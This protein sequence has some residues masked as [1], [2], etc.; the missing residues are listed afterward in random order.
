MSE[1][2]NQDSKE[3]PTANTKPTSKAR[4]NTLI[5]AVKFVA[6]IALIVLIVVLLR[7][8]IANPFV[9]PSG[10]MENTILEQDYILSEKVSY[11]IMN[12]KPQY[13]DI[14]TFD[15]PVERREAEKSGNS[16]AKVRTLIKRVIATEGQTVDLRDGC[17]YVDGEELD[18]PYT[19]G[20]SE[21]LPEQAQGVEVSFPYTVPA[22][23][24][25]VMGDNRMQSADS[26][27]FGAVPVSYISGKATWRY[28]PLN[29]IGS[30]Y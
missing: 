16:N 7:T 6:S 8:F 24:V 14:I 15:D 19:K 23:D 4:N 18:E 22:G 17:V 2:N 20:G 5:H 13:G 28:W 10:S 1:Q 3:Q 30:L 9:I 12:E 29:R 26:R 11:S 21:P 25:W 27:Y